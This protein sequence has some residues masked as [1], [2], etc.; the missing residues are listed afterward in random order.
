MK[1]KKWL[2]S[3]IGTADHDAS[4]KGEAVGLGPIATALQAG[5]Q[6]DRVC[7]LTNFPYERSAK[8]CEWLEKRCGYTSDLIDLQEMD[9]VSPIHYASIYDEVSKLL[10]PTEN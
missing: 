4:E 9:L 7:L 2:I 10:T 5:L 8:F 1:N 3:W 6:F